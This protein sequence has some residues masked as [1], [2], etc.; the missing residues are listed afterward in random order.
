MTAIDIEAPVLLRQLVDKHQACWVEPDNI[1]TWLAGQPG[2]QVLLFAG[3]AVRFPEGMDVAVVLP[4]LQKVS[5]A[6]GKPFGI[7]VAVP[8]TAEDLAKQFGSNR[9][10]TLMFFRDGRYVTTVCGMHDWTDYL[11]LVAQALDA[12]I[13]RAPTIGIPVVSAVAS[14]SH[15]H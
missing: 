10:P 9:W 6:T 11:A 8:E 1:D 3:D 15:C 2:N 5:A 12:P 7:A 4:E 14:G 13:S